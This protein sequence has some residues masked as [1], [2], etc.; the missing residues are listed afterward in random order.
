MIAVKEMFGVV[1]HFTAVGSQEAHRI[2]DEFQ[3]FFQADA[4]RSLHVKIPSLAEDRDDGCA[5]SNEFS[6]AGIIFDAISCQP[7]STKSRK[8]GM[9]EFQTACAFEELFVLWI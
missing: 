6:Y 8:L 4:Q 3:I 5:G 9:L 1:H 7:R 2:G